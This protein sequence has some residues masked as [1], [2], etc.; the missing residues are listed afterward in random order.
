MNGLHV[1]TFAR[2]PEQY[3]PS[4]SCNFS[5]LDDTYFTLDTDNGSYSV[6]FI[7]TNY[8]LLRIMGGQAGLAFEI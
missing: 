6:K 4:G 5:I 2:H 1:Y 3:Q 7:A 8:N